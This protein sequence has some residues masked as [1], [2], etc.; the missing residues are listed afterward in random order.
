MP[1]F[2]LFAVLIAAMPIAE[3]DAV[4][5][6]EIVQHQLKVSDLDASMA[7]EKPFV[8]V[9]WDANSAHGAGQALLKKS[10]TGWELVKMTTG[11]LKDAAL[12]EKLGVP[13][14]TAQALV[15]DL[16]QFKAP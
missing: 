13:A 12:L 10:G 3:S 5:V 15:K 4:N 8:V 9:F 11:S 2:M 16:T 7:Y 14:A 1:I 6:T